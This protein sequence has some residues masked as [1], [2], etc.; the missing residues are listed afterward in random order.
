MEIIDQLNNVKERLKEARRQ[1]FWTDGVERRMY[2]VNEM[3]LKA[4]RNELR[5]AYFKTLNN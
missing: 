4:K 5:E 1:A 3:I 2:Q